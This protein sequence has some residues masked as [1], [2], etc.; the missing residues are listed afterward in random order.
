[1]NKKI[2]VT[3][4]LLAMG[5]PAW[6]DTTQDEISMLKEQL[7]ILTQKIEQLEEKTANTEAEVKKV[8]AVDAEEKS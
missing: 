7:K 6:S 3:S 5:S 1:M 8:A 2:L 4:L